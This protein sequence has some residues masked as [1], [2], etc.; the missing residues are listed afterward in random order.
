ML[1]ISSIPEVYLP[2][3]IFLSRILDVSMGT[4]RIIFVNRGMKN[5]AASLGFFEVL[6]WI[7]V[8][9]QVISNMTDWINYVAYAGGFATGNYLGITIEQKLKVGTQVFRIITQSNPK[10]LLKKFSDKGFRATVLD[11]TGINGPEKIIFAIAK[12]RQAKVL[13]QLIKDFD[14]EAFYS[15]EDVKFASDTKKD[16]LEKQ[17]NTPFEQILSTRKSI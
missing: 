3:F 8:V 11:A 6:I 15:I 14:S 4:M 16:G 2:L 10:E 17:R 12:R 9:A 7:T 1:F 5:V 13:V